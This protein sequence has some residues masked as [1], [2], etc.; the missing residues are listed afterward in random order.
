MGSRTTPDYDMVLTEKRDSDFI[1]TFLQFI[2]DGQYSPQSLDEKGK[3]Y[4]FVTKNKKY[5]K[6]IE[7][8]SNKPLFSLH[9]TGRTTPLPYDNEMSLSAL[10]LNEDYY[11][12]LMKGKVLIDGYSV[13]SEKYLIAFK[14]KAWLDLSRRKALGDR[15][16]S[17]N[18]KKHLNDIARLA[19]ALSNVDPIRLSRTVQKD[20]DEFLEE[21][22]I[23]SSEIPDHSQNK[24]IALQR[25]EVIAILQRLFQQSN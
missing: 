5:P 15:V 20:M 2:E 9:G 17:K 14:A 8:F 4:R 13:L 1:K 22:S 7:L 10:I 16:D 11:E 3:L 19:G 23:H 12:L 6:M 24:E 18:V 21:V 25:E